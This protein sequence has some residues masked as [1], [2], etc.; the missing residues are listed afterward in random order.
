MKL[1][2]HVDGERDNIEVQVAFAIENGALHFTVPTGK[3][4]SH[5][6]KFTIDKGQFDEAKMQLEAVAQ[7]LNP[8]TPKPAAA[9]RSRSNGGGRA[10]ASDAGVAASEAAKERGE[11]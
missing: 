5:E 11:A 1:E 4:R 7:S 6:T 9:R 8:T 10:S 2:A 3:A